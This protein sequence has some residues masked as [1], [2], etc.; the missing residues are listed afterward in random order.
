MKRK[1]NIIFHAKQMFCLILAFFVQ[2]I[3]SPFV[4]HVFKNILNNLI[5]WTTSRDTPLK[6]FSIF[7]FSI[8]FLSSKTFDL[9]DNTYN[10][11]QLFLSKNYMSESL[12][13]GRQHLKLNARMKK[14]NI[15]Q[16]AKRTNLHFHLLNPCSLHGDY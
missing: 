15:L 3:N 1:I 16:F 9:I 4:L 6:I 12:Y 14:I 2:N 7:T 10:V 8:F 11:W 13:C 5:C